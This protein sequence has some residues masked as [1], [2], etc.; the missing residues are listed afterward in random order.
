MGE[1]YYLL[2]HNIEGCFIERLLPF[3]D[4]QKLIDYITEKELSGSTD[5]PTI[6]ELNKRYTIIEGKELKIKAKKVVQAIEIV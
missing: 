1:T 2:E 6:E 3:D 5:L 4:Y